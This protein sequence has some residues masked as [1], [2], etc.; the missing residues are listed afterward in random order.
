MFGPSMYMNGPII[1]RIHVLSQADDVQ[2]YVAMILHTTEQHEPKK[3]L[4][5]W[6]MTTDSGCHAKLPRI[7][8]VKFTAKK[9]LQ[10]KHTLG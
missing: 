2:L 7:V 3:Y 9:N 4:D 6:P 8:K 5:F 1:Y 10:F